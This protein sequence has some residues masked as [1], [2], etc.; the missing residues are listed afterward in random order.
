M[1]ELAFSRTQTNSCSLVNDNYGVQAQRLFD[2]TRV[3]GNSVPVTVENT[4]LNGQ[5]LSSYCY[6]IELGL[7][8]KSEKPLTD[9]WFCC[10][11]YA[12]SAGQEKQKP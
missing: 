6:G 10:Q 8:S 9:N 1:K 2:C 7:R 3:M 5:T 12:K 4:T 11:D